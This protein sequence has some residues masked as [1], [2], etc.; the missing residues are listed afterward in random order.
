MAVSRTYEAII[1]A[2][3]DVGEADRFLIL[4]T[5]ERGRIAARAA[6][7]RR[8]LSR[9]S[10]LLPLTR[11]SLDL[12][13][14][15]GSFLV[16]SVHSRSHRRTAECMDD[17]LTGMQASDLLLSLLHDE[18]PA[19]AIFDA[20]SAFL[21]QRKREPHHVTSFAFRLL[22][23]LGVLSLE[24]SSEPLASLAEEERRFVEE[25]ARGQLQKT[26][27][28]LKKLLPILRKLL[29]EHALRPLKST[30]VTAACLSRNE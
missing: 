19:P 23:L 16:T 26:S 9:L 6:G 22:F 10:G 29:E 25:S 17:F 11:T 18:E 3:Y 20:L 28:P 7:V 12:R 27:P 4:L 2:S 13:E 8:P 15:G 24:T 5:R 30:D 14:H 21:E 1:L